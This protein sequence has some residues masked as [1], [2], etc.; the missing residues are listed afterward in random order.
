MDKYLKYIYGTKW[1]YIC[2]RNEMT[3]ETLD[4]SIMHIHICNTIV[5]LPIQLPNNLVH[6]FCCECNLYELP[7]L[8]NTLTHLSCSNNNL[9]TLPFSLQTLHC[10]N[11]P[12]SRDNKSIYELLQISKITLPLYIQN[13]RFKN[14]SKVSRLAINEIILCQ[15]N[16]KRAY[17]GMKIESFI[18]KNMKN[19]WLQVNSLYNQKLYSLD[20]DIYKQVEKEFKEM[21]KN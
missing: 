15:Y 7:S 11:N 3:I 16:F 9:Q 2:D 20:N 12:F 6:L 5:V 4:D 14:K 21:I 10:Y 1:L 13:L 8:P 17:L 18:Y 19:E